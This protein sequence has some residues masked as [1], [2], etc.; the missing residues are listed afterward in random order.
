MQK[1]KNFLKFI[2]A[3]LMLFLIFSCSVG[4][5]KAQPKLKTKDIV[6]ENTDGHSISL[7]VELAETEVER[8]TGL[9]FR[10][11]LKEGEG[12]LFIYKKDT[13]MS[14][15]MKNTL[16]PLSTAFIRSDGTIIDIFD[17]YPHNTNSVQ[18]TRSARYALEVPQGYYSAN[19][20][21]VGNRVKL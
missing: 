15:W 17:M 21:V 6:I 20:I 18:S 16:I 9:M 4:A 7:K 12:M 10:K 14:F 11:D 5:D 13:M 8:N 2:L 1:Q 3:L 19:N